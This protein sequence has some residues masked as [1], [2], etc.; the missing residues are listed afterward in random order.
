[1][2][3]NI[4]Q[5]FL[6]V[7]GEAKP[8]KSCYRASRGAFLADQAMAVIQNLAA[9][10][11][12]RVL[13]RKARFR[14]PVDIREVAWNRIG[15]GCLLPK[16]DGSLQACHLKKEVQQIADIRLNAAPNVADSFKASF[17]N[18]AKGRADIADVQKI[19]RTGKR[20][21]PDDRGGF[22]RQNRRDLSSHAAGEMKLILS[23]AEHVEDPRDRRG[24]PGLERKRTRQIL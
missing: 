12:E 17:Q 8:C 15:P 20:A 22:A 21:G 2:R 18:R 3:G 11:G 1:M 4:P 23:R 7:N 10:L 14:E 9:G 13:R 6:R 19:P 16:F 5:A 24:N